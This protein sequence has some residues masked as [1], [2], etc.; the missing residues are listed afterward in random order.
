MRWLTADT[1]SPSIDTSVIVNADP[2]EVAFLQY[3]SGSTADPRGVRLTHA[4]LLDN[5]RFIA[6]KFDHDPE[7]SLGFNW[8]PPFHDMGL[9]GTILQPVD[10]EAFHVDAGNTWARSRSSHVCASFAARSSE[11]SDPLAAGH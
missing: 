1:T 4:S 9:I 5:S 2:S 10:F 6:T 11:A 8:I 3:T 7:L